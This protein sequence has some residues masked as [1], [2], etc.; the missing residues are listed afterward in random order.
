MVSQIRQTIYEDGEIVV[1]LVP[2]IFEAV[3]TLDRDDLK[4]GG[5]G[6]GRERGVKSTCCQNNFQSPRAI[7]RRVLCGVYSIQKIS[8]A[9]IR[10]RGHVF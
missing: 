2:I 3:S 4:P 9:D 10:D 1:I 6:G 8:T 5:G 7:L